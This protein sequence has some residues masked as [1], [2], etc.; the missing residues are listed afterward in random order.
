MP[1]HRR[2]LD[3][4]P[5][6]ARAREE[7]ETFAFGAAR[8]EPPPLG[9][10]TIPTVVHVVWSRPEHNIGDDQLATQIEALNR[11]LPPAQRRRV[12]GAAGVGGGG[13]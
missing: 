2:L 5:G 12:A 10:V 9:L 8:E 3:S 11:G 4:E 7:I 1:V 13:G 6:Y